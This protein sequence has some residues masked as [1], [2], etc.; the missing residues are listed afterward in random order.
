M[1]L[2]AGFANRHVLSPHQGFKDRVNQQDNL[3]GA[4]GKEEILAEAATSIFI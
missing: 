3:F 2:G 4:F 1:L